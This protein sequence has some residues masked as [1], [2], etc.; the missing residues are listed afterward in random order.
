[1]RYGWVGPKLPCVVPQ[2]HWK[3][4][5]AAGWPAYAGGRMPMPKA[6]AICDWS[7]LRPYRSKSWYPKPVM[8]HSGR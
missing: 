8:I 6:C 4:P 1:M 3:R 2:Y 7:A 5:E